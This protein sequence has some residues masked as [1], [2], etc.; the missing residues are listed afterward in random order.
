M[1]LPQ[2]LR[3]SEQQKD[4]AAAKTLTNPTTHQL[5]DCSTTSKHRPM[6]KV[7][8]RR[9]NHQTMNETHPDGINTHQQRTSISSF[10]IEPP[11]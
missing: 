5:R 3:P 2:P 8:R 1:M 11:R 10:M 7:F 6:P 4:P 9:N